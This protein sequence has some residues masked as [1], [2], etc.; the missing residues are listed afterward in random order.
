MNKYL[1]KGS[2]DN[3]NFVADALKTALANE[4]VKA[5]WT[6]FH[7]CNA[8]VSSP[9]YNRYFAVKSY[10]TVVAIIDDQN[11]EMYELGKWSRTT[12]KQVT[13]IFNLSDT[14]SYNTFGFSKLEKRYLV[15]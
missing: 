3:I 1:V 2:Q 4:I 15:K 8:W 7:H 13:Q 14:E 5:T 11:G 12:S 9:I 6:R 10:S